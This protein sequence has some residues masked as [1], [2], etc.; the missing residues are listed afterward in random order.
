M[1]SVNSLAQH[2]VLWDSVS[3]LK[4]DDSIRR[5]AVSVLWHWPCLYAD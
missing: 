4:F 5:N 3:Q 2:R 1:Y